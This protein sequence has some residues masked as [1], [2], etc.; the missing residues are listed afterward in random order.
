[1]SS[2]DYWGMAGDAVVAAGFGVDH[3][4]AV[5]VARRMY[6]A[7]ALLSGIAAVE[8][9]AAC[10]SPLLPALVRAL[11]WGDSPEEVASCMP[12]PASRRCG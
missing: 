6:N 9:V 1:M 7:C 4:L 10:V 11:Q 3:V 5:V 12:L 8:G 2:W